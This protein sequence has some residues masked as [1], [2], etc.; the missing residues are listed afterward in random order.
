MEA[1]RRGSAVH[2]IPS[3]RLE[4]AVE[5]QKALKWGPRDPLVTGAVS[6]TEQSQRQRRQQGENQR[7]IP[8]GTLTGPSNDP[9]VP[10]SGT[11]APLEPIRPH[12]GPDVSDLLALMHIGPVTSKHKHQHVQHQQRIT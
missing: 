11:R 4:T 6:Y 3:P 9:Q 8:I 1:V 7:P 10:E 5:T 2:R 12:P